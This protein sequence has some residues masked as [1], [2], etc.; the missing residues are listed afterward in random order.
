MSRHHA[1]GVREP[2]LS[3]GRHVAGTPSCPSA[4]RLGWNRG[5]D[6]SGPLLAR[7][8][9]SFA[10]KNGICELVVPQERV[11]PDWYLADTFIP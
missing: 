2:G 1:P 5:R 3:D 9:E 4:S 8:G 7:E 10:L 11:R 6:A